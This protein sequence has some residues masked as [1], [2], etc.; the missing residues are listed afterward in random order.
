MVLL[1]AAYALCNSQKLKMCRLL[2]PVPPK[3]LDGCASP[4]AAWLCVTHSDY[5]ASRRESDFRPRDSV[6][7]GQFR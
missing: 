3:K 1:L 6:Q 4:E 5:P 2:Y 7:S